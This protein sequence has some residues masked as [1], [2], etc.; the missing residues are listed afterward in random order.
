M[1]CTGQGDKDACGI[2]PGC[3]KTDKYIHP[4]LHFVYP[5]NKTRSVDKDEVV[6]DDFAAEWRK[7][8]LDQPYGR[9]TD[10]Y[11]FIGLENKQGA[12]S[13]AES[14]RLTAKLNLKSFES[15]YKVVVIWQPDKMHDQAASRLLKLLE[16]PPPMTLYILAGENPD[17]LL[18]TIK[19]RCV[20]VKVPRIADEEL[21]EI[22]MQKH[23]LTGEKA[24]LTIRLASGN[25]LKA[26]E[27]MEPDEDSSCRIRCYRMAK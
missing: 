5:V 6:G 17:G 13:T 11:D 18:S 23:G 10:W 25:Y 19:S 12:I 9:L 21:A 1:L 22:L 27:L 16:E 24:A 3:K 8:L 2:C 7:F 4:D 20:Q 14:R 15:D 26:L